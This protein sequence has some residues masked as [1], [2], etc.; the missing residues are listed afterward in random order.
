VH[1]YV[2]DK[3]GSFSL[4]VFIFQI[5]KCNFL[6]YGRKA[7]L[8]FTMLGSGVFGLARALA[9]S[10]EFFLAFEFLE[11]AFSG[12]IYAVVFILGKNTFENARFKKGRV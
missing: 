6:R 9:P 7:A 2:S 1:G 5:L 4:I 8:I 10:Y 12:G 11:A 3:Y